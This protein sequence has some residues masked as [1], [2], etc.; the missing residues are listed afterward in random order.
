MNQQPKM[1]NYKITAHELRQRIKPFALATG[2]V[3][4]TTVG[5]VGLE[6]LISYNNSAEL[7]QN[8]VHQTSYAVAHRLLSG[9]TSEISVAAT[10]GVANFSPILR[11]IASITLM[12]NFLVG[13]I[14]SSQIAYS[15]EF[16]L[17]MACSIA[18][19]SL[20]AEHAL[21]KFPIKKEDNLE[22][23]L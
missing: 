5:F 20:I 3:I 12:G 4:G 10:C 22:N 21:S 14:D 17:F 15:R 23:L 18:Y 1:N 2:L 8:V 6:Y 11:H 13:A 9:V 7:T 19:G 16:S